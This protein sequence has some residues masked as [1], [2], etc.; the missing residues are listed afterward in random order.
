MGCIGFT[1]LAQGL[2]TGKYLDGVPAG[3]RASQGKSLSTD[4]LTEDALTHGATGP[5]LRSAGVPWDLR[6][7]MPYLY[8]DQLDFAV[9]VGNPARIC[10]YMVSSA[11]TSRI[12]MR[13]PTSR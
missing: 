8:Y 3:S 5:I 13:A 2:L 12:P 6:R 4:L 11:G 1:A 9:V 10:R 7:A